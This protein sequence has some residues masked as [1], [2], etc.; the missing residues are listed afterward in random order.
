MHFVASWDIKAEG[1]E[2]TRI[3]DGMKEQLKGYSWVKP[4]STF[5]IIKVSS[6]EDATEIV[7]KLQA[8]AQKTPSKINLIAS[9]V[10]QGG[11]YDGM[12]SKDMWDKVNKRT[13]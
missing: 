11:R 12:L 7:K 8:A 4:L 13:D 6:G 9:P 10:M 1:D 5:Y 3:N 2:W